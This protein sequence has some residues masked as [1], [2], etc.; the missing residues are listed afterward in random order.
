MI[1]YNGVNDMDTGVI[2][3]ANS[4][5]IIVILDS[6]ETLEN[7][8]KDMREKLYNSRTLLKKN[9][10]VYVSFEGR[11]LNK[12]DINLLMEEMNSLPD[13]G[14]RFIYRGQ[15]SQ[16][17]LLIPPHKHEE[18][19]IRGT[20]GNTRTDTDRRTTSPVQDII[21]ESDRLNN[22]FYYGNIENGQTLEINKSIII[23][24]DVCKKARV[25]SKGNIIVIGRLSGTAIAGTDN[26]PMRFVLALN[27]EPVHIKIGRCCQEFSRHYHKKLC[28]NDAMIAY[29]ENEQLVF[30][31]LSQTSL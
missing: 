31:L 19:G 22:M 21:Q 18:A 25:I 14:V 11:R 30:H 12:Y 20:P 15:E 13:T 9:G 10:D 6:S 23:I 7:I 17:R 28:T 3:K 16:N 2:I 5:G 29:C 4:H 1:D 26:K 24:G 8:L 27:M